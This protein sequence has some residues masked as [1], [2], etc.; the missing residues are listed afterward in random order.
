MKLRITGGI[1]RNI[2]ITLPLNKNIRPT[3]GVVRQ[4]VFN[5][6]HEK[7][8]DSVFLDIFAGTGVMGIEAI[9]RGSC[10]VTFIDS[11]KMAVKNITQN[12]EKLDLLSKSQVML[13][14]ST[15]AI[16]RLNRRYDIVYI[17]A[18]YSLY[19]NKP[20]LVQELLGGLTCNGCLNDG[21]YVFVEEG[22]VNSNHLKIQNDS[23]IHKSSRKFGSSLLHHYI[24]IQ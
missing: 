8:K 2:S 18:P 13:S 17:D 15:K 21:A 22:A 11:D 5:I 19:V 16:K 1:F 6:C 24:Y 4:S 20:T 3:T 12:L 10:F 9:S 7:I 23:F 14:D